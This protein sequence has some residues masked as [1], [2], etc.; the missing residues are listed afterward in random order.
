M[1]ILGIG[2]G[3]GPQGIIIDESENPKKLKGGPILGL[4]LWRPS[5]GVGAVGG[6]KG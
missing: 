6:S 5:T 2:R 4:A 1:L 3:V